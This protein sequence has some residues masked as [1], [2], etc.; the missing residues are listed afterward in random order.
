MAHGSSE[1]NQAAAP[2]HLPVQGSMGSDYS[3]SVAGNKRR[4][5]K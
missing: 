4:L 5:L 2:Q 3:I 1:A